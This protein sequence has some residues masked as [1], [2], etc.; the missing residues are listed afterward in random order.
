MQPM[1]ALYKEVN[2]QSAYSQHCLCLHSVALPHAHL[3]CTYNPEAVQHLVFSQNLNANRA[4][5]FKTL[6][7]AESCLVFAA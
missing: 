4:L 6:C 1:Q 3:Y 7:H 2:I 5:S